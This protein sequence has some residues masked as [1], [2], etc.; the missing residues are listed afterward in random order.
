MP[1][2]NVHLTPQLV[3]AVRDAVDIVGHR[4][5]PHA[6]AQGGAAVPG[7]LPDPQGEVALVQR[8]SRAGALL[9][10][11]LRRR[12]RRHQAPHADHR[13]RLPGGDREPGDALRHPAAQP[14]PRRASPAASR[15]GTSRGRSQAAA[16]FFTR[17]APQVRLRPRVP[18]ETRRIPPELIERFG[19]GYAPEGYEN[20]LPAL[21]ARVPQS[22]LEAAGLVGALRAQRRAS[23]TA[24]ATG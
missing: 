2:G 18:G 14:R 10:L 4:L 8:R 9:L 6:A 3:Q 11:R 16:E 1:L 24:S 22:D 17:P 5:R 21:R 19:L 13:R 7:A 12:R 23:T 15:S 20:L